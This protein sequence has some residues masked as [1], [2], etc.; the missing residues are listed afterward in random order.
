MS[1]ICAL[2]P[3][4]VADRARPVSLAERAVVGRPGTSAHLTTLGALLYRAGRCNEARSYSARAL[5]LGTHDALLIF[6]RA[7]IERCLGSSSARP[8]FRRAVAV[9]PHFSLLWAPVARR[10]L[11]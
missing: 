10:A 6:H 11:R 9:N 4:A 8:W 5:R 2:A 1:F 7:M 3:D